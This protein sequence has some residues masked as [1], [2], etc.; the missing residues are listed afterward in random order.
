MALLSLRALGFLLVASSLGGLVWELS[1]ASLVTASPGWQRAETAAAGDAPIPVVAGT[2]EPQDVPIYLFA[3]GAVQA[4]NTVTVRS[5]VD[6]QLRSLRFHEGQDVRA[7]DVLV[8]IDPRPLEAALRQM[9]ANRRR[10][11]A[12][13]RS[14]QAQLQRTRSLA[15]HDLATRQSLDIQQALVQQL[16][17]TIDADQ[18]QID[19]AKV[20]LEYTVIRAPISGRVGLRL[21][22][23][24]NMIHASD[25][26]GIV[27]VR[28][29]QPT[30][31][32]FALPEEDLPKINSQLEARGA[33]PVAAFGRDGKTVIAE[34]TLT[35]LDNV[36]DRKTGTVKLKAQFANKQKTLWPGQFVKVRLHLATWPGSIVVSEA[37][38]QHG[39]QGTYV[40]VIAPDNTVAL[41]PITVARVE[42][43]LAVIGEGLKLGER[44]VVEGEHRL[45]PGSRVF[46]VKPNDTPSSS[47][48][49]QSAKS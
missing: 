2:V 25:Q 41:R 37:A 7:G 28:Q 13:L 17:A 16:E 42:N 33:L 29:L 38:V 22:D 1:H 14:A 12:Q 21:V 43:H 20:Q 10:D 48:P 46:E 36:I 45:Q 24:G 30:D 18:A 23:E 15:A 49:N 3:L 4:L 34:G 6:G 5:L 44:V 47:R 27:V 9:E 11:Q 31:V 40:F 8:T 39:A 19:N 35:A 26:N 32:V